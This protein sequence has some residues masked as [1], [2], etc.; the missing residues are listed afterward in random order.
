VNV[1]RALGVVLVAGLVACSGGG[2][3]STTALPHCVKGPAGIGPDAAAT[4]QLEDVGTTIC[5]AS[6]KV[7]T[8]F[9]KAPVDEPMWAPIRASNTNLLQPGNTGILTLVR[10]VTGAVFRAKAHGLMTLSSTRPPCPK[11]G[12][13]SCDAQHS[14]TARVVVSG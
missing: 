9:L 13:P 11:A 6:G 2:A 8:V 3:R 4:L 1:V 14:W 12:D 5:L 10:G 7:L